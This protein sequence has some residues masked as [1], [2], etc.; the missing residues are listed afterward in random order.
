MSDFRFTCPHCNKSL[1]VTE[2]V[3]RKTVLCPSCQGQ[4]T[5]ATPIQPLRVARIA[6]APQ[7]PSQVVPA[8]Q[9]NRVAA[10]PQPDLADPGGR[11][12]TKK[13][14]VG[15]AI[16]A[17]LLA[18]VVG[19]LISNYSVNVAAAARRQTVTEERHN[20]A[21]MDAAEQQAQATKDAAEI[22]AAAIADAAERQAQATEDA[23]D[24]QAQATADAEQAAED[25]AVQRRRDAEDAADHKARMR[26][27][28]LNFERIRRQR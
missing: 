23:A 6:T 12:I 16:G 19:N 7:S 14:V 4:V 21:I 24:Q 9:V 18:L 3:A 17:I 2:L 1:E 22:H 5:F 8:R 20:A 10:T 25:A 13:W 26:Q 15:F 11:H 27:L 28:E